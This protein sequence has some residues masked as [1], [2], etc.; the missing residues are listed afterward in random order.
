MATEGGEDGAVIVNVT[1]ADLLGSVDDVAVIVTV[2]PG[3]TLEGAVY[4]D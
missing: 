4:V 3:G 1:L 2:F